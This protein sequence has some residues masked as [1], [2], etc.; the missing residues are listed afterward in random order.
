MWDASVQSRRSKRGKNVILSK[1]GTESWRCQQTVGAR[2]RAY[3]W[4]S[5]WSPPIQFYLPQCLNIFLWPSWLVLST[6]KFCVACASG[7]KLH[8]ILRG[9]RE[10]VIRCCSR[11][12][13]TLSK[14]MGSAS[15]VTRGAFQGVMLHERGH[16]LTVA[17]VCLEL[18]KLNERVGESH[19][20]WFLNSKVR[21]KIDFIRTVLFMF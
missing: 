11:T 13:S 2:V 19:A 17:S 14:P 18:N 15:A 8:Q 12:W 4:C 21:M 5:T 10:H 16:M 7:C 6:I 9:G 3:A 1:S 20:A